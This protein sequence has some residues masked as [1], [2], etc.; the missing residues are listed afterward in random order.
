[1]DGVIAHGS[2]DD[3]GSPSP[4][5]L[6]G[7]EDV[8]LAAFEEQ[9]AR[10]RGYFV[11]AVRVETPADD[12]LQETLLR[13]WD[14]RGA[15]AAA[16]TTAAGEIK[17]GARR[18]LWRVARNLAIDE[19]RVRRGR[20]ARDGPLHILDSCEV[21]PGRVHPSGE[22]VTRRPEE[23][24]ELEDCL[25]VIRETIDRLTNE[26][27]RRCVELWLDGADLQSIAV[28]LGLGCG[29]VRGLLQR[30]RSEIVRR[31]RPRF[32]TSRAEPVRRTPQEFV[33]EA[34]RARVDA[35][36]GPR[37]GW[38]EVT[39]RQTPETQE[40]SPGVRGRRHRTSVASS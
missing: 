35:A 25:R 16:V 32:R 14:H 23:V 26:R 27:V 6:G 1:M 40:P 22:P 24:V 19:I 13:T 21:V 4:H 7:V 5:D 38:C 2:F 30:G 18:Y 28:N 3:Y 20:R 33:S 34:R 12:L 8:V 36:P 15:V 17:A 37:W 10:L 11:R 9:R 39:R 29:Q 31:A